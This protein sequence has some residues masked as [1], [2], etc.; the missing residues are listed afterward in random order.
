MSIVVLK[1]AERPWQV[2]EKLC[3]NILVLLVL[4]SKNVIYFHVSSSFSS[5]MPEQV[6]VYECSHNTNIAVL[7]VLFY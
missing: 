6:R 1:G 4:D 5:S 7:M 3:A 2:G